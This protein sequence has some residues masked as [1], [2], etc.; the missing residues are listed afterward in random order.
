M[1]MEIS[2]FEDSY[3]DARGSNKLLTYVGPPLE[4]TLEL[5]AVRE[6]VRKKGAWGAMWNYDND[7]TEQGPWY[8]CVCDIIDYDIKNIESKNARH[9]VKRSLERCIFRKIDYQWL[10][11]IG[12]EVYVNAS[13]RYKNFKVESRDAFKEKMLK[14]SKIPGAEAFGVFVGDKLVAYITLFICGQIV[15][16]DIAHFDPAYSNSYPMFALYY[17]VTNHYLKAGAYKEVDRGTR[18]LMHETNI[19]DFLLRMGYRKRYCRLGFYLSVPVRVAL[20]AAR[21]F[22]K[23]Y[24]CILPTR[25]CAILDGLLLAQDIA[26]ETANK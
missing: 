20:K 13:S 11:D 18:P 10:A 24:S 7:Y 26:E 4:K 1:N 14:S 5:S 17:N 6:F 8:R 23:Q 2:P 25:Y 12:Y 19:D 15:R 9:N 22:R 21:I 3:W 16:G